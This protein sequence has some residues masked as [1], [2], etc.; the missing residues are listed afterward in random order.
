MFFL[1][2]GEDDFTSREKAAGIR[3][4]YQDEQLSE[5]STRII[6]GETCS[7]D[8]LVQA[9]T[10][11]PFL[12]SHQVV[13]ARRLIG[14]VTPGGK[15]TAGARGETKN[16]SSKGSKRL[17]PP[18]QF[19]TF[20]AGLPESTVFIMVEGALNETNPYLKALQE[21][22]IPDATIQN[23]TFL[24]P[25]AVSRW[26]QERAR[27][28]GV[29]ID[30]GANELLR[31][32]HRAD[33]W[34][35]QSEMVKLATF[36][37]PKGTISRAVVEELVPAAAEATVF[38]LADAIGQ[39]QLPRALQLLHTLQ[40]GGAAP[41]Y[42]MAVLAGRYRDWLQ[43]TGRGPRPAGLTHE[44]LVDAFNA[45]VSADRVLKTG[46]GDDRIVVMDLLIT[47]LVERL[48][49]SLLEVAVAAS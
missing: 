44:A 37:G 5:F 28:T 4:Q 32:I 8:D 24:P 17:P 45:L 15:G 42:I 31:Q 7:W 41:E 25:Q 34:A 29:T 2:Y 39:R 18:G 13:E 23:N 20:V 48:P 14:S 47:I 40:S 21:K 27:R 9:C 12:T 19:A 36:V 46:A 1:Y 30:N 49:S 33:L 35:L 38:A 16:E 11:L 10:V 3:A 43:G 26:L 22:Q 6:D